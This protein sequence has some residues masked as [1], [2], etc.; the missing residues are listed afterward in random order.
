MQISRSARRRSSISHSQCSLP[1]RQPISVRCVSQQNMRKVEVVSLFHF[2]GSLSSGRI[3]PEG[4]TPL[5][6]CESWS[7]C[8]YG[9]YPTVLFVSASVTTADFCHCVRSTKRVPLPVLKLC[10][11]ENFPSQ[12]QPHD[13]FESWFFEHIKEIKPRMNVFRPPRRIRMKNNHR[14]ISCVHAT[15]F[16]FFSSHLLHLL[17]SPLCTA[18]SVRSLRF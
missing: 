16:L 7:Q 15:L 3:G 12:L 17:S 11:L 4:L 5:L 2:A 18:P 13:A 6:N 14:P 9:V 1:L 8:C 10:E